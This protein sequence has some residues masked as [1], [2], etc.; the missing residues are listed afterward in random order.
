MDT[1]LATAM[2]FVLLLNQTAEQHDIA[3]PGGDTMQFASSRWAFGPSQIT[4]G[5]E[6]RRAGWKVIHTKLDEWESLPI[7]W[8]GDGG[9]AP[10]SAT[11]ASAHKFAD[12]LEGSNAPVPVVGI[13]GDGEL[14]FRWR[15]EGGFASASFWLM[16]ILSAT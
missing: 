2:S 1:G 13:A 10:S 15:T 5:S 4:W 12:L 6:A 16:G 9:G 11:L 7:D 8:D 3:L 14:E